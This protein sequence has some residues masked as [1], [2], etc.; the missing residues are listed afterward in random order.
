MDNVFTDKE[1]K[2]IKSI[3]LLD[4]DIRILCYQLMERINELQTMYVLSPHDVDMYL[5]SINKLRKYIKENVE[6]KY[7]L[8]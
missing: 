7:T 5:K 6:D 8:S 3:Q 4:N 1:L 2:Q